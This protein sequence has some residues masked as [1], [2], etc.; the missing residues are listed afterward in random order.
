MYDLRC[1][2]PFQPSEIG[3]GW[4]P[5]ILAPVCASP[6]GCAAHSIIVDPWPARLGGARQVSGRTLLTDP[7]WQRKKS[8][9]YNILWPFLF[10]SLPRQ[11]LPLFGKRL[12][13]KQLLWKAHGQSLGLRAL[14]SGWLVILPGA[15]NYKCSLPLWLHP[16]NE[17]KL[18]Y[19]LELWYKTPNL[20][21]CD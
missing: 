4:N 11:V 21:K 6:L 12:Y 13:R 14:I 20:F 8:R 17:V 15:W 3:R 16:Y 10:S 2:T 5:G 18:T 9:T 1:L 19:L 7:Q